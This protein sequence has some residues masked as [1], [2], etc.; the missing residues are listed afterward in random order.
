MT[1]TVHVPDRASAPDDQDGLYVWAGVAGP[2][3]GTLRSFQTCQVG[4]RQRPPSEWSPVI[5]AALTFACRHGV[6]T[7]YVVGCNTV[8]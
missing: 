7:V 2:E 3:Y 5:A 6:A 8:T 1:T 4:S